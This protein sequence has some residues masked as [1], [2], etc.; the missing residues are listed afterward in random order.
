MR[1]AVVLWMILWWTLLVDGERRERARDDD[2][3]D[4]AVGTVDERRDRTKVD[5]STY[6]YLSGR[7]GLRP[8]AV[9]GA[10]LAKGARRW[11]KDARGPV[12]SDGSDRVFGYGRVSAAPPYGRWGGLR[13]GPGHAHS[14]EPFYYDPRDPHSHNATAVNVSDPYRNAAYLP[15]TQGYDAGF[16]PGFGYVPVNK[17][18][19]D[20]HPFHF[21]GRNAPPRDNPNLI[22]FEVPIPG[23]HNVGA[24]A[25]P[26]RA[27]ER[28]RLRPYEWYHGETHPVYA[29][30]YRPGV[31]PGDPVH[32][33]RFAFPK[34]DMSYKTDKPTWFDEPQSWP[35]YDIDKYASFTIRS[36]AIPPPEEGNDQSEEGRR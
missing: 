23:Y 31:L 21:R 9:P 20:D 15:R 30:W 36:T 22:P 18:D 24:A 3:D 16:T 5:A 35:N 34:P 25:R 29:E 7:S 19:A 17:V 33:N 10:G 12:V 14:R 11:G 4:A 1:G 28:G 32:F 26:D 13:E 8:D 2:D 6:M 27:G